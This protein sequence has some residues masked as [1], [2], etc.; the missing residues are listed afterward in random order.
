MSRS[1][2]VDLAKYSYLLLT[3]N[4]LE[5]R[6]FWSWKLVFVF[7]KYTKPLIWCTIAFR[8]H[9]PE[10]SKKQNQTFN[11]KNIVLQGYLELEARTGTTWKL[12]LSTFTLQTRFLISI[13]FRS[14]NLSK[15]IW[16]WIKF[17]IN[18]TF[19]HRYLLFRFSIF[20]NTHI[21][22][23]DIPLS[24][25]WFAETVASSVLVLIAMEYLQ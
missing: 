5:E 4:S 12:T 18:L 14:S 25:S 3:P 11:Y 1:R 8:Y 15:T 2:W 13:H 7:V 16:V 10:I 23:R 24:H 19:L 9:N 22:N 6:S 21:N 17:P 20:K